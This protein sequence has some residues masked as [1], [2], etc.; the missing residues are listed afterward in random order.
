MDIRSVFADWSVNAADLFSGRVSPG[1]RPSYDVAEAAEQ[2]IAIINETDDGNPVVPL[3][4]AEAPVPSHEYVLYRPSDGSIGWWDED[5][6]VS[7][8]FRWTSAEKLEETVLAQ[9]MRFWLPDEQDQVGLNIDESLLPPTE[10]QPQSQLADA[11][12]NQFFDELRQYVRDERS[13]NRAS[14][15]AEFEE[16]GFTT[17]QRRDQ[18]SGPFAYINDYSQTDGRHIFRYQFLSEDDESDV[19]LRDD[20]ELFNDNICL[21]IVPDADEFVTEVS[22]PNV[23]DKELQLVALGD[24]EH[25]D[26]KIDAVL[27]EEHSDLWLYPILNPVPYERRLDAISAVQNRQ[28]KRQLV[29]GTRTLSYDPVFYTPETPLELNESQM[30]ALVWATAA[31]DLVCIHGPPGTGKTRTLTAYILHALLQGKD[32]LVSAHSNQ[33][34]DNLLVGDSTVDE[35]EAGTLHAFC[36]NEESPVEFTVARAGNNSRNRTVNNYYANRSTASADVVAATTSGAAQFDSNRFDV[37]VVDE[38]TQATRPATAIALNAAKKLILA[39]DHKQLPPFTRADEEGGDKMHI[40]LFE[41]LLNRYGDDV[42]V[43]LETQYRMH[44]EIASFPAEQFYDGNLST[45]ERNATWTLGELDPIVGIDLK[46]NEQQTKIGSSYYN[47][48]EAKAA[49]RQ[50]EILLEAGVPPGDIGVITAYTGQIDRIKSHVGNL[51]VEDTRRVTVDTVDSFQGSEREAIIVSFVRSN[52]EYNT[53]F[54]TTPD[55]GPRRLNVAIT[56]A[57]KRLVLIGDWETLGTVAPWNDEAD[58]CA[59]TYEALANS[60]RERNQM[61]SRS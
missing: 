1:S 22:I 31:N 52:D 17:A 47:P 43:Q 26:E 20:E 3:F 57:K 24:H 61:L 59:P 40:S 58:S 23:G 7:G 33:A 18:V 45:A 8:T 34:V 48:V 56:R 4:E 36:Q 11:A 28:D 5:F 14:N 37:A 29:T 30:Q 55:E 54:L 12:V 10:L 21:A 19:N 38:A 32:I 53:G 50:V 42:K 60:L 49:A 9:R 39:G 27:R 46:G 41:H 44:R 25:T 6:G 13:R 35:P 15:R 2:A 51:D 16:M